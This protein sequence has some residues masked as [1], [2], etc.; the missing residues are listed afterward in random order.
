VEIQGFTSQDM[1]DLQSLKGGIDGLAISSYGE[2]LANLVTNPTN[3]T[4]KLAGGGAIQFDTTVP[5]S[6][7]QF[8][9]SSS[10][11]LV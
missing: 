6:A 3:Y 10:H 9:F 11:G 4:L 7:A 2:V 8:G 5:F 1:V